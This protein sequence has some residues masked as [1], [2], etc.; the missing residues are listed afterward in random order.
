MG[1]AN[2]IRLLTGGDAD[3]WHAV[4]ISLA[5]M[6]IATALEMVLGFIVALLLNKY[7]FKAKAVIIGIMIIPLAMTPSIA[8]QMWKLMF[9]SEYGLLN[10]ILRGL[11]DVSVVW[12]SKDLASWSILIVDIWQFTPFVALIMYAGLRSVPAE[13][14][15]SAMVDGARRWR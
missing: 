8:G 2:Y 6:V 14:Y 7:E 15:E 12:L 5:F 13:P 9:N 10:Y 3:F 1:L 11:F 4:F